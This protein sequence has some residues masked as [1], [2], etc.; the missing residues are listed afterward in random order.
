VAER[1]IVKVYGV[2]QYC[3]KYAVGFEVE[4]S[5]LSDALN[6]SNLLYNA[7]NDGVAKYVEQHLA[8]DLL[9]KAAPHIETLVRK[10]VEKA[11]EDYLNKNLG[12]VMEKVD[13]TAIAKVASIS[14]AK[15]LGK[16]IV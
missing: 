7:I 15:A 9:E 13:L 6:K 3:D 5:Q 16:E 14:A 12:N 10:A 8:K 2:K 1:D 4:I 11:V